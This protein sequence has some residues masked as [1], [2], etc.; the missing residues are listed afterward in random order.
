MVVIQMDSDERWDEP[1]VYLS[2]VLIYLD[3]I[4]VLLQAVQY[5]DTATYNKQLL[6]PTQYAQITDI[7]KQIKSISRTLSTIKTALEQT[8]NEDSL[9][10]QIRTIQ[11]AVDS[12]TAKAIKIY[13]TKRAHNDD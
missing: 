6:E 12:E 8:A 2:T 7:Y 9:F 13:E 11:K 1:S 10:R 5:A 3:Y 4:V